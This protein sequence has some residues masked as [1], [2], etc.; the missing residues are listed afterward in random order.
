M[1]ERHQLKLE[2]ARLAGLM[3]DLQARIDR[4]DAAG[5]AD[6]SDDSETEGLAR[7]S[8][9]R[10]EVLK[11]AGA[12]VVGA[13]GGAALRAMPAAAATGDP[14]TL[15]SSSNNANASTI[16]APTTASAPSPMLEVRG[17]GAGAVPGGS[18]A[19]RGSGSSGADG[20][21]GYA[22]GSMGYGVYG[23]SDLGWGVV[24][25]S[26]QGV[27]VAALGTGRLA[28]A[29]NVAAGPPSFTPTYST[30]TFEQA[31]DDRG[32]IWVSQPGGTWAPVQ[33]GGLNNALFVASSNQQYGLTGSNGTTW[34]DM[35]AT[36]LKLTITPRF[37]CLAILT[38]NCDLWTSTAGV[39]QDLGIS[40]SGG[41]YPTTAGQ[42]EAWKESGGFA[43]TFSPNAAFV[44]TVR[45]L[46]S[47][48]TY[49]VKLTWKANHSTAGKIWAGAGPQSPFSPTS[50]TALLVVTA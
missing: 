4:L 18:G 6:D 25:A 35:D 50:L 40:I 42:P 23:A 15:G 8:Q 5:A 49:T 17:S 33:E 11:L 32:V 7:R 48:V 13:A 21:D 27:D 16:L 9:S 28:Q 1:T 38:A 44:Q 3:A 29:S 14:L 31:R 36:N 26:S 39:N 37:N 2:A 45:A 34:V 47:G 19:L 43:G 30:P 12:A 10:R 46:Q 24:G 22:P 41:A 20:V